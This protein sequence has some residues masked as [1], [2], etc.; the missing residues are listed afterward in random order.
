MPMATP[1]PVHQ[2]RLSRRGPASLGLR[3]RQHHPREQGIPEL[4]HLPLHRHHLRERDEVV[5]ERAGAGQGDVHRRGRHGR[6]REAARHRRQR[7]QRGLE[8]PSRRAELGK[9]APHTATWGSSEQEVQL[10]DAEIPR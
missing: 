4:V 10:R 7:P 6:V 8:R 1:C 5:R 2:S 3:H 9:V